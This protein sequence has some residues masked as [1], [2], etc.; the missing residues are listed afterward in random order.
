M[1]GVVAGLAAITPAAGYVSFGTAPVIGLLAGLVCYY[2]ITM[3]KVIGWDDALDVW[4]VHGVGGVL[5][6]ILLGVF[7]SRSW[8]PQGAAGLLSGGT[9]FFLGQCIA[10]VASAVWAFA[11]TYATL[12]LINRVTS[13]RVNAETEKL[14]LDARLLGEAAYWE[15]R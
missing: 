13:I 11:F 5:G 6:T 1:T 7:A 3:K 4:G 15:D 12:W 8:N 10:V 9:R 14:G 2:A